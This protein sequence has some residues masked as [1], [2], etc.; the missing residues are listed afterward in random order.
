MA[1]T[2]AFVEAVRRQGSIPSTVQDADILAWGDIEVQ[3]TFVPLLEGLR[4]NYFVREALMST[5]DGITS[6]RVELPFRAI[7]ASLRS[8][9]LQINNSW[10]SLPLRD[11]EADDYLTTGQPAAYYVDA[12]AI[13]LLPTGTVG[14]LRVRYP[15][16]PPKMAVDTDTTLTQRI[17][18]VAVLAGT[19][20][21]TLGG[22]F[23]GGSVIDVVSSGPAHQTKLLNGALASPNSSYQESP[24]AGDY[25]AV[26]E[27]SPFVPIPE[28]LYGALVHRTAGVVLRAQGY[29]EEAGMQLSLAG[30]AIEKSKLM[31]IPRNEGNPP[32]VR[33][34]LRKA[35]RRRNFGLRRW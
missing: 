32:M 6:G 3:D 24:V 5:S 2:T 34:G 12:G 23:T 17:S 21:L 27:R 33:G 19:V 28:E 13:R 35:L 18:S 30:E 25:V 11:M 9:Q 15:M 8:V 4:S 26:P 7:G 14:Q 31:L 1:L 16:R 22:A 10:V 20:T 29:D